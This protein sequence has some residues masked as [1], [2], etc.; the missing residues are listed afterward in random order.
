MSTTTS[1][2]PGTPSL[3]SLS[4]AELRALAKLARLQIEDDALLALGDDLRRIVGYVA[5]L[6]AV[7]TEGV[8][9]MV[10][11]HEDTLVGGERDDVVG[12]VLGR[13]A[14]ARVEADGYVRVPKV[15]E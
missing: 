10:H 3:P 12:E 13:G 9:P 2:L 5:E 1:P 15:I 8:Q 4:L 7:N 14:L 11:P 6:Q